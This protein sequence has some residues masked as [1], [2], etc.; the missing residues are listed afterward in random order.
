MRFSGRRAAS[1]G[2][3][4]TAG[5]D[6]AQRRPTALAGGFPCVLFTAA[7]AARGLQARNKLWTERAPIIGSRDK[8]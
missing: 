1:P 3:G 8:E 5:R 4:A 7:R 2:S 6:L